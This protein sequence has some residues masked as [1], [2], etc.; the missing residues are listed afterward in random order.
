MALTR[1]PCPPTMNFPDAYT[2]KN[3]REFLA[4]VLA[5]FGSESVYLSLVNHQ[6]VELSDTQTTTAHEQLWGPAMPE[7]ATAH[8]EQAHDFLRSQLDRRGRS[9]RCEDF[10]FL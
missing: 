5:G 4:V 6:K 2:S 9:E 1:F 7:C 10:C 8:W 3:P